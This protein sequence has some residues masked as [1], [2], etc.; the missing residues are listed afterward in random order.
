MPPVNISL[1][2]LYEPTTKTVYNSDPRSPVVTDPNDATYDAERDRQRKVDVY[3]DRVEHWFLK[4][5]RELDLNHNHGFVVLMVCLA[6]VEGV[7]QYRSGR[8]ANNAS[9]A[10]FIRSADR[11]FRAFSVGTARQDWSLVYQAARCGL[12]HQGM[13]KGQFQ[14]EPQD[15][16]PTNPDQL[17]SRG[18]LGTQQAWLGIENDHPHAVEFST[19]GA[20]RRIAVLSPRK[21]LRI[22]DADFLGYLRE[23]RALPLTDPLVVKFCGHFNWPS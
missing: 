6:Y 21:I 1:H 19:D 2:W 23:L 20:M 4:P 16:S 18:T 14:W 7:E 10:F 17:T 9:Q 15:L 11:L 22:V 12:F 13:T 8:S 5:A 3:E